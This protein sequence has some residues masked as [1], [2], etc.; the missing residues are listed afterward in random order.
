MPVILTEPDQ[1]DLWMSDAPWPEVRPLQRPL[2][3]GSLKVV[4]RGVRED[5]AVPA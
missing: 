5:E 1:W 3:D 4:A 2:P